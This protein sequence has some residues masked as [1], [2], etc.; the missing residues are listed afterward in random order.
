MELFNT[1]NSNVLL[2]LISKFVTYPSNNYD[3]NIHGLLRHQMSKC[4][5]ISTFHR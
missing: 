2:T 4:Y 3:H 5:F 1:L